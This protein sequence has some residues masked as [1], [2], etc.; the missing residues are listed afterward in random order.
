[1]CYSKKCTI[2]AEYP[3]ENAIIGAFVSGL[4]FKGAENSAI[5]AFYGISAIVNIKKSRGETSNGEKQNS[6]Y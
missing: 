6:S 2:V 3:L 1:M 5:I 4:F